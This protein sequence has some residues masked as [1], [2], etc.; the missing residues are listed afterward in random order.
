MTSL[1][2]EMKTQIVV[3]PECFYAR[4]NE[5]LQM[6]FHDKNQWSNDV[7]YHMVDAQKQFL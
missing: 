2:K 3:K 4:F 6:L 7:C 1:H 5:E